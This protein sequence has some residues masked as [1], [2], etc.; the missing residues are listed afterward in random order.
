MATLG[1]DTSPLGSNWLRHCTK[2]DFIEYCVVCHNFLPLAESYLPWVLG[3]EV[4]WLSQAGCSCL[5]FSPLLYQ[6][7]LDP[8]YTSPILDYSVH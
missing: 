6:D 4:L 2:Y 3:K 7:L 5:R 8:A 1:G